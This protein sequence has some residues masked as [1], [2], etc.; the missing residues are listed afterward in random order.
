MGSDEFSK[1]FLVLKP[2][3]AVYDLFK[4]TIENL[5]QHMLVVNATNHSLSH[6]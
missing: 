6:C 4:G 5:A 1:A 3:W 2:S